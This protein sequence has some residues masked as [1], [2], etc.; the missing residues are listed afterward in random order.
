MKTKVQKTTTS[1]MFILII[2]VVISSVGITSFDLQSNPMMN[3]DNH[4]ITTSHFVSNSVDLPIYIENNTVCGPTGYNFPGNGSELNPYRIEN[5]RI[6]GNG[7]NGI[8]VRNTSVHILIQNCSLEAPNLSSINLYELDGGSIIIR[9]NTLYGSTHGVRAQWYSNTYCEILNNTVRNNYN[10]VSTYYINNFLIANNSI[11]DNE[12]DGIQV[13][14]S[15]HCTIVNNTLSNGRFDL[16]IQ[17]MSYCSVLNNTFS[18][19]GFYIDATSQNDYNTIIIDNNWISGK[20]IKYLYGESDV[21]LDDQFGQIILSLCSNIQIK[22]MEI[23]NVRFPIV[24]DSCSNCIIENNTIRES[25]YGI[26]ISGS[27]E[28]VVE[29]NNIIRCESEGIRFYDGFD[30][31]VCSNEITQTPIG[32]YASNIGSLEVKNNIINQSVTGIS[33]SGREDYSISLVIKEN[34]ICNS[35]SEGIRLMEYTNAEIYDNSVCNNGFSGIT[36]S[37]VHNSEISYNLIQQNNDYGLRISSGSNNRIHHNRFIDNYPVADSQAYDAGISNIWYE[38]ETKEGNYW[39]NY[40]QSGYY[41][42][43]GPSNSV[44]LY[45]NNWGEHLT[46]TEKTAVKLVIIL[47]GFFSLASLSKIIL[48]KKVK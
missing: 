11:E 6:S 40:D 42:I 47:I 20:E 4:Q 36:F 34:E 30:N 38:I 12:N 37:D 23:S 18:E 33:I 5:K 2:L 29:N 25:Y 15:S 1:C 3:K 9:N 8:Y 17:S 27:N 45:P 21:I 43:D 14:S 7:D 19:K 44:D 28:I 35:T 13:R 24:L 31:N 46:P 41:E 16:M 48:G 39:S 22:N 10:G 26:Y 32:I